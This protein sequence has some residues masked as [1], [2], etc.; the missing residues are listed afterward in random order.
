MSP[1][2]NPGPE[3]RALGLAPL[4]H[5]DTHAEE[6]LGQGGYLKK[7]KENEKQ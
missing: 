7:E 3:S 2:S 5:W 4:D 6:A 1:G